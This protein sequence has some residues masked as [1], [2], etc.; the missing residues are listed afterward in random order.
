MPHSCPHLTSLA[1]FKY[2]GLLTETTVYSLLALQT[3]P[4]PATGWTHVSFGSIT[5]ERMASTAQAARSEHGLTER[6]FCQTPQLPGVNVGYIGSNQYGQQLWASNFAT[7]SGRLHWQDSIGILKSTTLQ[8]N[9][10]I[11]MRISKSE[12]FVWKFTSQMTTTLWLTCPPVLWHTF[13]YGASYPLT[14]C[15]CSQVHEG[16]VQCLND[17]AARCLLA[18]PR[19]IL[20]SFSAKLWLRESPIRHLVV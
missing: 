15:K 14:S 9:A 10:L 3:K 16:Q 19:N 12:L 8:L 20:S 1:F 13:M 5:T 2:S 6:Y 17:A 7:K 11:S 4:Q 18:Q